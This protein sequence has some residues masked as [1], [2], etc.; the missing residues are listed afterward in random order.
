MRFLAGLVLVALLALGGAWIVA[1]RMA[2]P[3]IQFVQPE[4]FVGVSTPFEAVVGVPTAQL[5][6]LRVVLEQNGKQFPIYALGDAGAEIKDEDGGHARLKKPIGKQAVP[7]LVSG[8]AKIIVTAERPVMYKLRK[9]SST[10]SKDVQVRLER[11]RVSVISMHHFV[12][13]GGAEAVVYRAT[14]P[15]VMSGVVVGDAEYPGFSAAAA[16]VP[17]ITITDPAIKIAFFALRY[18]QDLKTPIHVFA[19]DEAGNSARADFDF[20]VF[21]KP[22]KKSR[23][24]LPD[25]FLDR[26]VPAILEGT[27]EVKPEGDTLAKFLVINGELRKK[28]NDKIASMTKQTS[29]EMLWR[30]Q[31]FHPFGNTAVEA[32]FAD[33]RTYIYKGKEVDRQT[34]LGF[35]LASFTGTPIVAANRGKVVLA[36][37]LGIYGNC[38]I[39]DHGLG[40]QS[41]YGHL[42]S[43]D[44]KAGDMVEKEQQ[45]GRSGMTGMAA[46]DHLHFTMLVNGTMVNP[47]EWWDAHWIEDRIL[48]KLREAR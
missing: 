34:H 36:E 26:V 9:V 31:V 2:G 6:T 5:T 42:S 17:G 7:D 33:Q 3:S 13:H 11:P 40:V 4:K 24:E 41:L 43:I 20:R 45:I 37:E 48:R 16:A 44:V 14:P 21:P 8:P 29:P 10:A 46:G 47:V 12:N 38:V 28:N 15:D 1:G 19:R 35:D 18:D 30:G 25:A 22:F 39:I 23:I 27:T 32:A